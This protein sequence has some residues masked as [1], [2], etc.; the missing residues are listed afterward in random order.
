[1]KEITL[2]DKSIDVI[3]AIVR[4]LKSKNIQFEW[5]YSRSVDDY[6]NDYRIP[7]NCK[8]TFLE[9]KDATF[10]ILKYGN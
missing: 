8:F 3:L 5:A 2:Y 7:K 1:M 10:F 4:E 6:I 9:D